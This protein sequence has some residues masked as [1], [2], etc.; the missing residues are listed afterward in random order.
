MQLKEHSPRLKLTR[1]HY[2][3]L[4]ALITTVIAENGGWKSVRHRYTM[5]EIPNGDR[6]KDIRVRLRGDL[7]GAAF[8]NDRDLMREV[9]DYANDDHIQTAVKRMLSDLPE[10]Q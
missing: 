8:A 7:A 2:D 10:V 1:A 5:R 3:R 6:V 9:D 4:A